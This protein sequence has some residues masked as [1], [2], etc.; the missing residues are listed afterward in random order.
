MTATFTGALVPVV[1]LVQVFK[2]PEDSTVQLNGVAFA[3]MKK[4]PGIP[5]FCVAREIPEV[6]LLRRKN[7]CGDD[8]TTTE[9]FTTEFVPVEME[10][11]VFK[12]VEA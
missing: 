3:V 1:T 7:S 11:H 12:S 2:S 6:G 9:T 5:A 10:F 8:A 4:E